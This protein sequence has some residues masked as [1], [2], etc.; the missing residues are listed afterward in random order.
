MC[1]RSGGASWSRDGMGRTLQERRT[2]GAVL[3]LYETDAYNLG[4]SPTSI[5]SLGYSIGYTYG[6][7]GRPISA[8]NYLT[9]TTKFVSGATYAPPGELATMTS[10]STSTFAGI[11]TSN[12][13]YKRLQPILLS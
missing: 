2:I 4:G 10:G 7:A 13:Y 5:T 11:V 8:T 3:G 6:A 1:E 12:A 9:P